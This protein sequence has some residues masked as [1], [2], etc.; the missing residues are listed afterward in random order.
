MGGAICMRI[1]VLTVC[2]RDER[3]IRTCVRQFRPLVHRH[4]VLISEK[5]WHGEQEPLDS[6]GDI[7][8]FENARVTLGDW[9]SEADQR[10]AGMAQLA[11]CDWIIVCD[12]DERWLH[13]DIIALRDF[14]ET[15]R[16]PA[17]GIGRLK[18]YW[19]NTHTIVDPEESGGLIVAVKPGVWFTEKRCIDSQW[20]FLPKDIVM[21][22]LSYVRTDEEM[23]RKITTFEHQH[24]IIPGWY[25]NKWLNG[26]ENLHPVN[27]ESFKGLKNVDELVEL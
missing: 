15:Q 6:C 11:D 20:G 9:E 4:I 2:Y 22:H 27:P 26:T 7:A 18:T 3:F 19:K 10:N 5:P 23:K 12:T 8:T 24:E 14:L 16:C 13:D 17:F 21:H 25:E 1:G